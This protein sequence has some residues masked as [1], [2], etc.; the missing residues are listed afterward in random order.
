[1]TATTESLL[2]NLNSPLTS[3]PARTTK[4]KPEFDFGE[5]Q[6]FQ[7]QPPSER[8]SLVSIGFGGRVALKSFQSC[9]VSRLSFP[10]SK[11]RTFSLLNA[12]RK[13][14]LASTLSTFQQGWTDTL[15]WYVLPES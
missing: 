7:V 8:M 2:E 14:P 1:M 5:S 9:R 13:I 15:R 12:S 11:P 4:T 10:V 6:T 3:Q